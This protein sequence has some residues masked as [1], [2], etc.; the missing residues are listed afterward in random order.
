[1]R[2]AHRS[3]KNVDEK[4]QVATSSSACGESRERPGPDGPLVRANAPV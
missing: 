4:P 3:R 2:F 1:V